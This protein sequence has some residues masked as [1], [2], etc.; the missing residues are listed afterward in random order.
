MSSTRYLLIGT[1]LGSA[2]FASPNPDSDEGTSLVK[3]SDQELGG[4]DYEASRVG[5]HGALKAARLATIDISALNDQLSEGSQIE[6]ALPN[7]D[8][9]VL[10]V[11]AVQQLLPSV[12]TFSGHLVD[13]EN[14]DFVFS[15]ED[16]RLVGSI[17]QEERVWLIEPH[18]AADQHMIRAVDR[19]MLPKDENDVDHQQ[20]Q[21][22]PTGL[23]APAQPVLPT[24]TIVGSG[25]VRILFL[26]ANNVANA[27]AQAANI[28]TAFNNSLSLSGVSANN[29]LTLA[30]VQQVASSFN[31]QSRTTIRNAM[32]S[33][34]APFA[35]IDTAM[36][37]TYADI[38][39][40]LV[41]EDATA[42]DYPALG[43]IGGVAYI[44]NQANPFALSTDDY[45]LGD[46]TALHE[47]GHIFGGQ[48]ENAGA[49]AGIARPV[50]AIDDTWMTIMGAYAECP[51]VGLP[52]TCVRLNRWSN[53]ALT[54]MGIPIGVAGQRDMESHLENAMPIVS[55]WRAEPP[56]PPAAPNPLVKQPESCFGL[57]GMSWAAQPS[58]TSYQLYRSTSNT[59]SNPA[60]L[61]SGADLDTLIDVTSGTWYLRARACNAG[62]CSG[63]TNQVSATRLNVCL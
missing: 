53:P 47:I 19:T 60:M 17:R 38:A 31:G 16:G 58:A 62:G 11:D 49:G 20:G 57:F 44:F 37:D 36:A 4:S 6:I 1:L 22:A 3:I 30:G 48:H 32:G 63:W 13:D 50:V 42:V 7:D 8:Q 5:L 41:Q 18:A 28:V 33:R 12:K 45:A 25:N 34:S 59:F 35:S 56:A 29:Y 52:A 55:G 14:A 61:Y 26:Y 39:F 10:V 54:H 51:F 46:L 24:S 9:V 21:A 15:I 40:L 23:E 43:R 2:C 27:N